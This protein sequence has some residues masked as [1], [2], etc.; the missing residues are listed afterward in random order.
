MKFR[1]ICRALDLSWSSTFVPTL[2]WL[3]VLARC[4]KLMP[5]KWNKNCL[6]D[7]HI[8]VTYWCIEFYC[9]KSLKTINFAQQKQDEIRLQRNSVYI[10]YLL[11]YRCILTHSRWTNILDKISPNR[12]I[13]NFYGD[14]EFSRW[15]HIRICIRS[16]LWYEAIVIGLNKNCCFTCYA[17]TWNT[18]HFPI[19]C[20]RTVLA[21]IMPNFYIVKQTKSRVIF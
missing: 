14:L 10:Y 21:R 5:H 15:K 6:L 20:F 8:S 11:Y 1:H 19:T 18:T 4:L 16:L 2:C 13:C 9:L 12:L 17:Q 7:L 3:A